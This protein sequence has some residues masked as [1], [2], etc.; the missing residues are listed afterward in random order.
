MATVHLAGMMTMVKSTSFDA[1][2][3]EEVRHFMDSTLALLCEEVIPGAHRSEL[4]R[5]LESTQ[6]ISYNALWQARAA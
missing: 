2:D 3:P 6:H 1:M 4:L 5:R